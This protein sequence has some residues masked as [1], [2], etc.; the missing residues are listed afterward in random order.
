MTTAAIVLGVSFAL[1]GARWL[2][3]RPRPPE[4]PPEGLTPAQVDRLLAGEPER[5][6]YVV[7]EAAVEYLASAART[8]RPDELQRMRDR[9]AESFGVPPAVLG[10][11]AVHRAHDEREVMR[12]R[13]VILARA[14]RDALLGRIDESTQRDVRRLL[15]RRRRP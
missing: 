12:S 1:A 9:L 3:L 13:R 2:M 15:A 5:G 14:K 8:M 6:G 11:A 7:P 4:A 10:E